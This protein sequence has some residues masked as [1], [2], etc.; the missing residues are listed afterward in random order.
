MKWIVTTTI[1]CLLCTTSYAKETQ[2]IYGLQQAQHFKSK[3]DNAVYIQ[4]ESFLDASKAERYQSVLRSKTR[5]PV[6]I[7]QKGNFYVVVIGPIYSASNVI[8]TANT[9]LAKNQKPVISKPVQTKASIQKQKS[10]AASPQVS[11]RKNSAWFVTVG[12]GNEYPHFKSSMT[13]N[14]DSE[15]PAP[16]DQ[17]IYST[18]ESSQA[19]AAFTIGRRFQRESQWLPAVSLGLTYQ[20]LFSTNV[21]DT[22]M[23]YSEPE[24]TNY[25][26]GWDVSSNVWLASLKVNLIEYHKVSPYLTGGLGAS[27]NTASN[28]SETPLAGLTATRVSPGFSSNTVTQFAYMVGAGVDYEIAPQILLSAEY[29]YKDLGNVRSGTGSAEWSDQSLNLGTLH[30]SAVLFNMSYLIDK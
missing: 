19:L 11:S 30:S 20:H 5:Y 10:E 17:D 28:Y 24:F 2:V 23:Q 7:A 29:Q 25:S 21:G 16:Y 13:V 22:V 14:N 4:A 1:L 9:L 27:L 26:Y 15:A 12:G 8:K 3:S 18:N 6:K